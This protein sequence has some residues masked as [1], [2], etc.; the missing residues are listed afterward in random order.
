M[1]SILYFYALIVGLFNPE[2]KGV[3]FNLIYLIIVFL[4]L[5]IKKCVYLIIGSNRNKIINIKEYMIFLLYFLLLFIT[6]LFNVDRI[7]N[8]DKLLIIILPFLFYFIL[9]NTITNKEILNKFIYTLALGAILS[10]IY[11]IYQYLSRSSGYLMVSNNNI[12]NRAIA[13]FPTPNLFSDYLIVFIPFTMYLY[14][15]RNNLLYLFFLLLQLISLI[16]TFSRGAVIAI[17]AGYVLINF[18]TNYYIFYKTFLRNII[19]LF[20]ITLILIVV[21]KSYFVNGHISSTLIRLKNL[22]NSIEVFLNSPYVGIGIGNLD[23]ISIL[24]NSYLTTLV[25]TG[26]IGL[27]GL[28]ILLSYIYINIFNIWR[29]NKSDILN[30]TILLSL[31]IF[32]IH[33]IFENTFYSTIT[34][35]IIGIYLFYIKFVK[36]VQIKE[37]IKNSYSSYS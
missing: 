22:N 19:I 7:K 3:H 32:L 14:K 18:I 17:I 30:K 28:I 4:L 8:I 24:D 33:M 34:N 23:K 35:W 37:K 25:Q 5:V 6:I 27:M 29:L 15:K 10:S 12:I 16:F 9:E 2:I 36:K 26:I 11:G 21:Y 31:T 13:A 20:I 1:Q